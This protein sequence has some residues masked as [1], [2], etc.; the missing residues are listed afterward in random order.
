MTSLADSVHHHFGG[1]GLQHHQG[2]SSGSGST[3]G[4]SSQ[5]ISFA[6][7]PR[8]QSH[9]HVNAPLQDD[10]EDRGAAASGEEEEDEEFS[11]AAAEEG[12]QEMMNEQTVKAGYLWK[13]GEKRKVS[14]ELSVGFCSWMFPADLNFRLPDVEE[15]MVRA[16]IQ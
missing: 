9:A 7:N 13:K 8:R 2:P 6:T 15:E 11:N 16:Q 1:H 14:A 4:P 3:S 10:D 5:P 12:A